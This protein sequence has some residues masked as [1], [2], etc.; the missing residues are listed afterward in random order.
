M[1]RVCPDEPLFVQG[2]H[3]SPKCERGAP[4]GEHSLLPTPQG[5]ARCP[6][7]GWCQSGSPPLLRRSQIPKLQ[8]MGLASLAPEI[9]YGFRSRISI[10]RSILIK[11][12]A[13]LHTS[14]WGTRA[15]CVGSF[16]PWVTMSQFSYS[17]ARVCWL[18][19]LVM[20]L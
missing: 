10:D 20:K 2:G 9:K 15:V 17:K 6:W 19:A 12:S 11:N 7:C 16:L 1:V 3:C 5:S 8:D 14:S 18:T 4:P 13:V